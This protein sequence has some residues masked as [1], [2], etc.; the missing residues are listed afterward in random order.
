MEGLQGKGRGK[1]WC[2][3]EG[4][5]GG[6]RCRDGVVQVNY[7]GEATGGLRDDGPPVGEYPP[8]WGWVCFPT[9]IFS[10]QFF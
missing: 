3:A 5:W 10:P 4:L 7:R 9:G 8:P 6:G 1:M 2:S